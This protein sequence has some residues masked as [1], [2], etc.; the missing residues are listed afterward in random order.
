MINM[1]LRMF[2]CVYF[3]QV[4]SYPEVVSVQYYK[5]TSSTSTM[6]TCDKLENFAVSNRYLIVLKEFDN[7]EEEAK[8]LIRIVDEYQSLITNTPTFTSKLTYLANINQLIGTLSNEAVSLVSI[9]V[10]STYI[11]SYV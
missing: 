1:Q 2:M 3:Q 8:R 7:A 11:H 10:H 6:N 9:C 4:C 5:E